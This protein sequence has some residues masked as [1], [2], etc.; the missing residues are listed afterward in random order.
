MSHLFEEEKNL[1]ISEVIAQIQNKLHGNKAVLCSEF[2]RQLYQ[3]MS[4]EDLKESTIE[5]LYGLAVNFWSLI[6]IRHSHAIKINIYNPT[7]EQHGWESCH[8]IIELICD[9][10]SFLVDSLRIVLNRKK[11]GLNLIVHMG[12]IRLLR[13]AKDAVSEVLPRIEDA[14]PDAIIEAPILMK[15]DRQTDPQIIANLEQ[16]F[17]RVLSENR[18]VI[19]DWDDMR[20][21]VCEIADELQPPPLGVDQEDASETFAFLHWLEDHH[22]T[23]IGMQDYDLVQGDQETRL[24]AI[25]GSGFGILRDEFKSTNHKHVASITPQAHEFMA[26]SQILIMSKTDT[27]SCIH[28]DTYMDYIGIKRF[29]K[30]GRVIGERRIL[31]LYTSVAYNSNPVQIPFLRH[32]LSAILRDS[33]LN[34]RSHAGRILLNIMETL[35]RDDLIQASEAELL[36]IGMGIYYMQERRQI[37]LFA[38]VDVYHRF[39]SCLVYVPKDIYNSDIRNSMQ[40][41]L[42]SAFR[43]TGISFSTYFPESSIMARVHFMV[44]I[45]PQHP[46]DFDFKAI[47]TR[48]MIIARSWLDDLNQLLVT[49]HGLKKANELFSRYREAIPTV[50]KASFSP[51]TALIDISHIEQLS[52]TQALSMSFFRNPED[53]SGNYRFKLYQHNVTFPLSDVLPIVENL[54]MRAISERPYRLKFADGSV[55]WVNDFTLHYKYEQQPKIEEIKDLFK[56]AFASIWFKEIENDGF[57]QLV[58]LASMPCRQVAVLR[59]YA[60]YF[61]QIGFIFSQEYIEKTLLANADIAKKLFQMFEVKFNQADSNLYETLKESVLNDL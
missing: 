16:K 21:R 58:L 54:G 3:T 19:D 7:M 42:L 57:N 31:G 23:F 4:I 45:D 34:A 55:T 12:G 27:L 41:E 14:H 33:K 36:N 11:I 26:S 9:D 17:V 32:K 38:R 6:E 13:D 52:A 35:P 29:D 61:K 25:P 10:M 15:I 56:Q 44:R 48:L 8:T 1:I 46:I 5:D 24:N 59:M 28:R 53:E 37:R 50:Y 18:A 60:K 47:E 51:R 30:D 43:A 49:A 2:V 39:I 40:T 20:T 22:F